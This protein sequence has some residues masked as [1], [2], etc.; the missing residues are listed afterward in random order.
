[1]FQADHQVEP[2]SSVEAQLIEQLVQEDPHWYTIE[3]HKTADS[4][5][6]VE[7]TLWMNIERTVGE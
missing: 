3:A 1:M 6:P 5:K 4:N 7:E 2:Q